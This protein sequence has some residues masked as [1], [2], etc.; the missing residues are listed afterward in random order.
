MQLGSGGDVILFPAVSPREAHAGEPGK[1]D[2]YFSKVHRLT[3]LFIFYV[4][5]SAEEFLYK[6]E[7]MK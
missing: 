6:F 1:F 2:F 3:Y 7:L 4:K 5:F